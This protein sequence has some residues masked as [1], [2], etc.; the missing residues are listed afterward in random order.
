MSTVASVQHVLAMASDTPVGHFRGTIKSMSK[1]YPGKGGDKESF[2]MLT[3]TDRAGMEIK[4]RFGN[5]DEV[6]AS[7]VNQPVIISSVHGRNGWTGLKAKDNTYQGRTERILWVTRS[8]DFGLDDGQEP[9]EPAAERT[10]QAPPPARQQA[11]APQEP[12]AQYQQPP[13]APNPATG[14]SGPTTGLSGDLVKALKFAQQAENWL[15]VCLKRTIS[16]DQH[17]QDLHGHGFSPDHFQAIC[18]T[19][20]IEGGRNGMV[21]NMPTKPFAPDILAKLGTSG[22]AAKPANV[23]PMPKATPPPPPPPPP[24]AQPDPEPEPTPEDDVPF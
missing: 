10:Q 17:C 14:H 9:G 13:Q 20:F 3:L 16:A 8:A 18:Q 11:P 22:P 2:Q 23:A 24:P 1:Y 19:F 21:H 5:R 7:W 6:Q 15:L 12:P 4:A